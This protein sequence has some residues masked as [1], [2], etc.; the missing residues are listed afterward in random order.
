MTHRNDSI[1]FYEA[2]RETVNGH[3]LGEGD[4]WAPFK[5]S[6]CCTTI[7]IAPQI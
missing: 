5:F 1:A 6:Q 7:G 2:P 3:V 4:G